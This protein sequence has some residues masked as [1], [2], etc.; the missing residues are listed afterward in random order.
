MVRYELFVYGLGLA[1]YPFCLLLEGSSHLVELLVRHLPVCLQNGSFVVVKLGYVLQK[2]FPVRLFPDMAAEGLNLV[3]KDIR[4][5]VYGCYQLVKVEW[6]IFLQ[7]LAD[8]F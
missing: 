2:H 5:A 1:V 4:P 7:Q 8:F 6:L 3:L